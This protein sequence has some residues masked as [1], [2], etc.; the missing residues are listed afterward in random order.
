MGS[1]STFIDLDN[2]EKVELSK[3]YDRIEYI[4]IHEFDSLPIVQPYKIVFYDSL[5]FI[6]DNTMDNLFIA[7]FDGMITQVMQASGSGPGEFTQIEDF[8]VRHNEVII[9]DLV[10]GKFI[11]FDF[12][13]NVLH[14]ERIR[15]IATNFFKGE[16]F[17]IHFFNNK[18][19][20]SMTNFVTVSEDTL[21][22][23]FYPIKQK[24]IESGLVF[25][26][27]NGFQFDKYNSEIY[28]VLPFSYD[29]AFFDKYGIGNK[30]HSFD[31]GKYSLPDELR[32]QYFN[33]AFN[34]D[35][36]SLGDV[37]V[38]AVNQF[39]TLRDFN[40]LAIR[41]GKNEFHNI[42]LDKQMKP[43]LQVNEFENDVD[44]LPHLHWPSNSIDDYLIVRS[45]SNFILNLYLEN[46]IELKENFP[47]SAIHCFIEENRMGLEEDRLAFLLY[48]T[49]PGFPD[50]Q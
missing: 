27:D 23:T 49:K 50:L 44:G 28:L 35:P 14:E 48:K 33:G 19:N 39:L 11:S 2:S 16:D 45:R 36:E 40:Y 21:L 30:V 43:F 12:S 41:N 26:L 1:N 5:I 20:E 17:F 15:N 18:A 31:F 13:G 24:F 46:E 8:Q 7:D 4:L 37:Y 34:T 10:S 22:K 42:F 3:L 29:V 6:E 25:N 9:K 38:G 32:L 47:N